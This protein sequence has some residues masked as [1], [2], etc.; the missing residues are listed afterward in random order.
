VVYGYL[1]RSLEGARV[2]ALI[3]GPEVG[4]C[5]AP[6]ATVSGAIESRDGCACVKPV[7]R[8]DLAKVHKVDQNQ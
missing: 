2:V 5:E 3:H 8:I 7:G 6:E 1:C 4:E